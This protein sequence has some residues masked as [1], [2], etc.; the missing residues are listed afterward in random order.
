MTRIN[1]LPWREER[2]KERQKQ[3]IV[4]LVVAALLG[5]GVWAVGHWHYE[6]LIANQQHRNR[7]LENEIK[8]LDQRIAKIK[9][10]ETVKANLIA[11]MEVIQ[12]LQQGRPQVV[13]LFHQLVTTLPDGVYLTSVKQS[14]NTI[15]LKGVAESNA[16][17]SSFMENLDRSDWL[18]EPKLDVIQVKDVKSRTANS[19]PSRISEY[20]LLVKQKMPSTAAASVKT[21]K[22]ADKKADAKKKPAKK[23]GK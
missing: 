23:R 5:A 19:S 22:A 21:T 10:L 11:R 13:H 15:T 16:R 4:M 8:L 6:A 12:Q 17:I 14:G 3:F 2:R 9:D 1:L 18:A 20:T 7:I